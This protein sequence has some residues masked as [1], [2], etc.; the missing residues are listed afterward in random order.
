MAHDTGEARAADTTA[1]QEQGS[2]AALV[3]RLHT[4]AEAGFSSGTGDNSTT[5]NRGQQQLVMAAAAQA[6]VCN[7][8]T[9]TG[10]GW[11]ADRDLRAGV[12]WGPDGE[13]K[14]G[15]GWGK[16]REQGVGVVQGAD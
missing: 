13:P 1:A 4:G 8:I 9:R 15:I 7:C 11:D 10:V 12:G 6:L 2:V 3:V 14:A 5:K 16:Y